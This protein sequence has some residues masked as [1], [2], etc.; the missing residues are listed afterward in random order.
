MFEQIHAKI[1]DKLLNDVKGDDMQP[2]FVDERGVLRTAQGDPIRGGSTATIAIVTRDTDNSWLVICANVGDSTSLLTSSELNCDFLTEEHAPDN[3]EEYKRIQSLS[4]D[5]YP[6]KLLFV[7]DQLSFPKKYECARVF[8][9]NGE[10][11]PRFTKSP[12]DN[13]LH[14]TNV[15]YEPAV[16][17]VTSAAV[18]RD[19]ACIAMTRSVGDYYAH[20]FGMTNKPSISV[21]KL[22][23]ATDFALIVA[24][25]GIW[26]C[27][28][29][30]DL[31]QQTKQQF[32]SGL[33]LEQVVENIMNETLK[34]AV[35]NFGAK[36]VDDTTLICAHCPK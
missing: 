9:E 7:Y 27:W 36:N 12:W 34:C 14:P 32:Q 24:T 19:T 4:E 10:K 1:R 28:V 30:D 23:E 29:Y 35:K 20:Q 6:Q 2:N 21:R 8:L 3:P 17:A 16:Y 18:N 31:V 13:G 11:D 26:D 22:P 5:T 33:S 15:R 25:D